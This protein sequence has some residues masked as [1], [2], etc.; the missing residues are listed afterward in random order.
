MI[1]ILKKYFNYNVIKKLP[2]KLG[3]KKI[4]LTSKDNAQEIYFDL[5]QKVDK[6]KLL[7]INFL[8]VSKKNQILNP[9]SHMIKENKWFV[10]MTK[11][12]QEI[13]A[14]LNLEKP[15]FSHVLLPMLKLDSDAKTEPLF[16]SYLFVNFD[17]EDY[18]W[19]KISNTRGVK[20][21]LKCSIHP[22]EVDS[23]FVKLLLNC[24]DK[25]GS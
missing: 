8:Y 14:K 11:P 12:K 7:V 9:Q 21:I 23:E 5:I 25:F 18:K 15:E 10:V 20:K 4:I 16:P 1:L 6:S 3:N 22:T 24:T 17:P 19:L 13:K 2:K